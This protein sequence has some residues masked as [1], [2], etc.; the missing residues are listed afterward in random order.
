M[1]KDLIRKV[2]GPKEDPEVA[3]ARKLVEKLRPAVWNT[4]EAFGF[5]GEGLSDQEAWRLTAFFCGMSLAA[6]Q[7]SNNKTEAV[8]VR[9]ASFLIRRTIQP[10]YAKPFLDALTRENVHQNPQFRLVADLGVDEGEHVLKGEK[11]PKLLG[12]LLANDYKKYCQNTEFLMV[13]FSIPEA[14]RNY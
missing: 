10:Q 11:V 9:T 2:A 1:L 8:F 4:F 5:T 12:A 6:C 13:Y 3:T 7:A 14:E